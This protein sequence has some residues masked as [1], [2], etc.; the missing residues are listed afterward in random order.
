MLGAGRPVALPTYAFQHQSYWLATPPVTGAGTDAVDHP[1]LTGVVELPGSGGLLFSGRLSPANT[2]WLA[3]HSVFDTV[4]FPGTGFVELAA[5]AARH[6]GCTEV[7]DLVLRAPL[8]LPAGGI[9]VQVWVSAPEGTAR[10]FVVRARRTDD[11][12]VVHATG[13]LTGTTTTAPDADWAT[14]T[15]PPPGAEPLPVDGLYDD[16]AARGYTYGPAFRG[17]R[18][19]WRSSD[20]IFAEV[21]LPQSEHGAR[22]A[23]HPALLDSSLHVLAYADQ[24]L[25][26][27]VRLPFSFA[28]TTLHTRGA[29]ALRVRLRTDGESVRLD[30]ATPAG[31]PVVAVDELVLRAADAATVREGLAGTRRTDQ[32]WHQVVWRRLPLAAAGGRVPGTWLVLAPPGSEGSATPVTPDTVWLEKT[33][34]DLRVVTL[35]GTEDRR[36][37]AARLP[38]AAPAGVLCLARRPEDVL[39]ALQALDDAG[40]HAPVWC[41][42]RGV[43]DDPDAAAVWGLGRVA[44]LELPD[45]WGGLIDLPVHG[46]EEVAGHLAAV[47]TS[48]SGEDQVRL[49]AD[50][51]HVRRLERAV[52]APP[53]EPRTPSGTV[54]ITG[55]SGALAGHVA[56]WLAAAGGCSLVLVSRRGADAPGAAELLADL[57]ALGAEARFAGADVTDRAAM[58]ELVARAA[59]AGAP[60]R[61]VFHAAGTG[62]DRP[63]LDTTPDDLRTVMAAKVE[64]ARVLDEVLGD[65]RLDAFVLFSSVSGIWG[66]AGQAGYA[67]ANAALDALAARRR[68]RGL[69][70]TS[71]AWGPWAGGGMV[72]TDFEQQLRRRGLP[73][74]PVA[75]AVAALA[76]AVSLGTD[77][78]LADVRWPRF[79]PVFTAARP[80]R[81]FADFTAL[82]EPSSE[83]GERRT[84]PLP[85]ELDAVPAED[86]A[87]VLLDLVRARIAQIVG[88]SDGAAVDPDRPLRDLG[89]DSLMSVELRNQLSAAAGI[90]LS[91]TLVFD[92]PTP[93]LLAAHLESELFTAE[94]DQAATPGARSAHIE[95]DPVVV[96]GMGCRYPGDVSTPDE[97]WQLVSQGRD[98]VGALP[99]DRGWDV[100]RLYDPDPDRTGTFYVKQGGFVSDVAGFDARFFGIAPREAL[101]MDPQQR[102]ML[103]TAWEAAE[104]AG[105]DPQSLRGSRTG[106][107]AGAMYNDYLSRLHTTPEELEGIIGIANSN[108]VMSGR[109]SYLLGLEGPAITVDTACSSSLVTLHL[110]CEA[111]RRGECDL[112]FAGGATVMASPGIFIEFSR[113]GGLAPDG[114]SKSFSA[115][116]DG[117][118]WSEGAG[119]LVLE[120]LSD[121]RRAG[122]DVLAVIRGSAVNQDGAS[123]GLTAPNGPAQERVIRTALERSG[124]TPADVDVVEAHG[125]G[126][127]LGDPIEAQAL[128][129]TY[130]KGHDAQRPLYLGSVKSNIGHTQAAAGVAGIIKMVQALRHEQMPRTLHADIPSPE[131]DWSSGTVALLSEERAWPRGDRPRTAA[132]SSFG[133]SGTNAHVI[134]TEGDPLPAP[135]APRNTAPVPVPVPLTARTSQA[136]P[137]QARALL[138]HLAADE[139]GP[140]P[141]DL[142]WSLA[143]TRSAFP[144]RA[145]VVAA[146]R[147]ELLAGLAALADPDAV[148][149]DHL[150]T[151]EAVRGRT[152]LMFPGQGSQWLGM[153]RRLL[154]ENEVF[155]AAVREC[156][157]A[158]DPWVEW[159][160]TDV[161]A[162][163]DPAA[164]A[165]VDVVQPVLFAMMVSLARVWR[166]W[167][168][169]VDGVVGHSQ[170]EIAAACVSGALSLEDAARVVAVRSRLLSGFT[171]HSGLLSVELSEEETQRR[172]TG[173]LTIAVINGPAAVVV[174]GPDE[175][176]DA[177]S[178]RLR[179]EGIRRR[180]IEVDYA[181]HSPEMEPLREDLVEALRGIE[182]RSGTLPF[183]S[184]VTGER[185]DGTEL[186]PEYWFRN[187]RQ[188]VRMRSA[189]ETLAGDGFAFFV[190]SSPHPGLVVGVRETLEA[191][192]ADGAVFGSLRRDRGGQEHFLRSLA[193]GYAH[194][195]DVDWE[196]VVGAGRRVALPT[197]AFQR[198]R[199]WLEASDTP[200]GLVESEVD[201]R[202]WDAVER[203]DLDRLAGEL[204][205]V[206]GLDRML[207]ALAG[208]RRRS[209]LRSRLDSWQYTIA[210]RTRQVRAAVPHGRWLVL[211]PGTEESRALRSG[212]T[213]LGLDCVTLTLGADDADRDRLLPLLDA[214]SAGDG[215]AGVLSLLALDERPHPALAGLTNGLALSVA[216]VQA[217]GDTAWTA[218]MWAVTT[219]AT[220]AEDAPRRPVQNEVWGLGRVVALEHPDRWGG[221]ADLPVAPGPDEL[222]A[223]LGILADPGEEDQWSVGATGVRVRRLARHEPAA[224]EPWQPS[225]TVLITGAGGSLGPHLARSVVERGAAHVA[226]LSRRGDASPGTAELVAELTGLGASVSVFACDVRDR[227]RLAE[228]LAELARSGRPVTTALHAAA[229]LNIGSLR[230]T[231]LAD[232]ADVV[233]AKVAGAVNLAE[234]LDREHLRELVLFS[235]I[236]GVWGSGDHGAYAAANSFLDAY[237]ARCRAD[238][239]PVTSV[240][241]GIWDEQITKDRTDAEAVVRRGL[242]FMDRETGFEGLYQAMAEAP[243][244]VAVADVDWASFVPVFTSVR[245]SPLIGELP[246]VLRESE[247]EDAGQE[248]TERL[249]AK[250]AGMT[251]ADRERTV[252]ELVQ[253]HAAAVLG[254]GAEGGVAPHQEFRQTGMDSLLSVELRNRLARATGL[255]L[256]PTLV[257]DHATPD[258]LASHL[259]EQLSGDDAVSADTVMG[260]LDEIETEIR[261]LVSDDTTR[262]R[263]SSRV[264]AL[265]AA[266]RGE[267]ETA[268]D[269]RLE[270]ADT[271]QELLDLLDSEFGES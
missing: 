195:L 121:A 142:A 139:R 175:E 140:D 269:L 84:G 77:A 136:L 81:L 13:T 30:A 19:A 47:L 185:L 179:E 97:L 9:D 65:T 120:R 24:K 227:T 177:L 160:L 164:L 249:R 59:A 216:A 266:V 172:L 132:V 69:A 264:S 10:E 215:F 199:Y 144:H 218:P 80:A 11:Q 262:M 57:T 176:L 231:T 56:R 44:A 68:G 145:V 259:L 261:A 25:H 192:G 123:N 166:H 267:P 127:R 12:W 242:P 253:A 245:S 62:E 36:A 106:V 232:F 93:A 15:W 133:I 251:P 118:G 126:T 43:D 197:Y 156:E 151:G 181:S 196:R 45:R 255:A 233:D 200:A 103:E 202:F 20:E 112:A 168:V 130:G 115:Q 225:G 74:L 72:D 60:V 162:D 42:T 187:L 209:R 243:A 87:R 32:W 135:A 55:G 271:T 18:A 108:S 83:R 3:D 171:G 257:F 102:L 237:A 89:F 208:W 143:T 256:P 49:R 220:D 182:P 101:A 94:A 129:A 223:L 91:A 221:L 33:F 234:L 189:V 1:L 170:G 230:S 27:G 146:D 222:T 268:S 134:L 26:D 178:A 148:R 46:A 82:A 241:W 100:A 203:E 70:G 169:P 217:L 229:F 95:D 75:G 88:R 2:A 258:R 119:I 190:E 14:G 39:L 152:V 226:L 16:L 51:A 90:R 41:L 250:L 193:E 244:F 240:A 50:G 212:L 4:L 64:G 204:G 71:L 155:A 163:E 66:S 61:G 150:V 53:R 98:A 29:S 125:T 147:E 86:R 111:L 198:E 194:G 40:T 7:A 206:D 5:Q 109:I 260:R 96:I 110:A 78:V 92:H 173:R 167:G 99:A 17:L 54:L 131:V 191:L 35:D 183:Y 180:R 235:S 122:H 157:A 210:W 52:P 124:L 188:T 128:L 228:V 205:T 6:T 107:F 58:S 239:L 184:T 219:G 28:G 79:L 37:L 252:L 116:A 265:L 67:A 248:A 21:A 165:P 63:L 117:T 104:H 105:I 22:F 201:A 174:A 254:F 76:R 236:A 207:P 85:A 113:Q 149:P 141:A 31:F 8:E 214:A 211:E 161:L 247:R 73:P 38:D 48:D 270:S 23:L 186:G 158:L 159:S 238:G 153:A 114:R 213:Q 224:T 154:V 246:E 263:L 138:G 137:A 34:D